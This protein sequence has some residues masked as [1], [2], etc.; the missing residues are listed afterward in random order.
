MY[1]YV[2]THTHTFT[3]IMKKNIH[4]HVK[5][6]IH[7]HNAYPCTI[8][9]LHCTYITT[10]H[11]D[12]GILWSITHSPIRKA[13]T[14]PQWASL[15]HC[16]WACRTSAR[17]QLTQTPTINS[18]GSG[19]RL[20]GAG[21]RRQKSLSQGNPPYRHA[22]ARGWLPAEGR[23]WQSSTGIHSWAPACI[24]LQCSESRVIQERTKSSTYKWK[25]RNKRNNK[26][27]ESEGLLDVHIAVVHEWSTQETWAYEDTACYV[28]LCS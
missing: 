19:W 8:C 24:C 27:V 16:P 15:G 10:K 1:V 4:P 23:F 26:Q 18:P 22:P 6:D 2:R 9:I 7:L 12:K 5:V 21:R 3:Y 25:E 14:R 28:F 11:S 20:Q 17:S 13:L